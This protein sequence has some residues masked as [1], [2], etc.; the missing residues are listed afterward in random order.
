MGTDVYL[1]WDGMTE[2][3]KKKQIT[4]FS[5]AAGRVGYL[6]A[7]IGM[8]EENECLRRI[9]PPEYWE[10]GESLPYDF[11]ANYDKMVA[12]IVRYL[13]EKMLPKSEEERIRE[14][15]K[16]NPGAGAVIEAF[17]SREFS[18]FISTIEGID[19]AIIWASSVIQFFRLGIEKQGEGKNPR[20]YISW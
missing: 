14:I 12:E 11:K 13:T 18:L 17:S 8:I 6:R 4:G 7:S 15:I 2:E 20:V 9:F 3:D 5:I 1:E 10:S 16:R 19:D